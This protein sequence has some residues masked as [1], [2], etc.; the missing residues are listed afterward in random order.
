[1]KFQARLRFSSSIARCAA[2][3]AS[4]LVNTRLDSRQKIGF[5]REFPLGFEMMAD[6]LFEAILT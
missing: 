3:I 2:A 6:A 4:L 1:L 5:N